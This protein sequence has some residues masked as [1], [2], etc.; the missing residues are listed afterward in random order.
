MTIEL[1]TDI[2]S[3]SSEE[4]E[5]AIESLPKWRRDE[6]LKFH[7]EIDRKLSTLA[8]IALR[9][10]LRR[11]FKIKGD[12]KWGYLKNDKPYLPDHPNIHFNLSH[13]HKA[14]VCVVGSEPIGVDVESTDNFDLE[15]ARYISNDEELKRILDS[16]NQALEFTKL[17]TQK[18]SYLKFTGEGLVDNLKSLLMSNL[19]IQFTTHIS[20]HK[21]YVI[22]ICQAK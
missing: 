9:K 17:W 7:R 5:Q 16:E 2:D 19:D 6:V 21:D 12:P 18:E 10:V 8:Y 4:L 20:P 22:T 13:C 11:D 15:V 14:V 3:M 1:I